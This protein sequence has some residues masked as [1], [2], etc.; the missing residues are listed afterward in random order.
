MREQERNLGRW[1][2][3][4]LACGCQQTGLPAP[5]E[6]AER[7]A[8]VA[9]SCFTLELTAGAGARRRRRISPQV[10]VQAGGRRRVGGVGDLEVAGQGFVSQQRTAL[11]ARRYLG[12]V[13]K[14]AIMYW[15][16]MFGLCP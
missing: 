5:R 2:S 3:S 11:W 1:W 10:C 15:Q 12:F 6:V 14:K 16:T 9:G 4:S 8:C 7:A 13:L